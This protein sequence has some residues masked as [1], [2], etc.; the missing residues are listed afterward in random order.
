M[1]WLGGI[2]GVLLWVSSAVAGPL[3]PGTGTCPSGQA[4]TAL[5]PGGPPRCASVGGSGS[6]PTPPNAPQILFSN[7]GAAV[8]SAAVPG[9]DL[10]INAVGQLN[11]QYGTQTCST[12][13]C[14]ISSAN[15]ICNSASGPITLLLPPAMAGKVEDINL[16]TTAT[17]VC[18]L[19]AQGG[20]LINGSATFAIPN[21]QNEVQLIGNAAGSWGIA[22]V[23]YPPAQTFAAHN[24]VTGSTAGKLSA[25]QPACSDLTGAAAHCGTNASELTSGTLPTAQL[26]NPLPP[27]NIPAPTAST[28]GG[29]NSIASQSHKFVNSIGT[30]GLP[31]LAQPASTDLSDIP[32]PVSSGCTGHS[33]AGAATANA[34][35]AAA[36]GNNADIT[37]LSAFIGPMTLAQGGT[38]CPTGPVNFNNLPAL[39]VAGETCVIKDPSGCTAQLGTAIVN[40]GGSCGNQTWPVTFNGL[41]NCGNGTQNCWMPGGNAQS[42]GTQ[43]PIN[44]LPSQTA[45][46]NANAQK[47][48]NVACPSL[49]NDVLAQACAASVTTATAT[50]SMTTPFIQTSASNPAASGLVRAA[51]NTTISAARNSSNNGDVPVSSVD[52]ANN[53][54]LGG[55]GA[56]GL[57]LDVPAA[58]A[59][60]SF[61][62]GDFIDIPVPNV[63][64]MGGADNCANTYHNYT[65]TAAN[66]VVTFGCPLDG[67]MR[68]LKYRIHQP[69]TGSTFSYTFSAGNNPIFTPLGGGL[70]TPCAS[71]NCYDDYDVTFDGAFGTVSVAYAGTWA[72][73][74]ATPACGGTTCYYVDSVGGNDANAGTFAAP[75]KNVGPTSTVQAKINAGSLAGVQILFKAG[76]TWTAG[77][78]GWS[79]GTGATTVP[80]INL[81][82][83]TNGSANAPFVIGS[84]GTGAAPLFNG[85]NGIVMACVWASATGTGASPIFSYVT[86]N[87]LECKNTAQAGIYFHTVVGGTAGMPG[88]IASSNNIHNTGPGCST[89]TGTCTTAVDSSTVCGTYCNQ[90]EFLDENEKSDGTIFTNNVVHDCGG[91][92][93]IQIHG[94]T[95]GPVAKNNQCYGWDH[96]CIDLKHVVN[97]LV[98]GNT[99]HQNNSNGGSC[100]YYENSGALQR[101]SITW[102]SNVVYSAPNGFQCEGGTS[103]GT[104]CK[105]YNNT[106]FVGDST[107][108]I[109]SCQPSGACPGGGSLAPLWDVENNIFD[110]SAPLFVCNAFQ[111]NSC[112]DIVTWNYNDDGGHTA[113]APSMSGL[114]GMSGQAANDL[115]NQDPLY[116]SIGVNNFQL[117]AGSP[118]IAAGRSGLTPGNNDMGAF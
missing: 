16:P 50:T 49:A 92:N 86:V 8:W 90:L 111:T 91:H 10:V 109:L 19:Q 11:L 43:V 35:G 51:N 82:S 47:L 114:T 65:V 46:Y 103:F 22:N 12:S 6:L 20:D 21:A 42:S 62:S 112:G 17:N 94:D 34:I 93:C 77:G 79:G 32:C 116:V 7:S 83:G 38:N 74:S 88:I 26:P 61:A 58:T 97:G 107:S 28:L 63:N 37:Q 44:Q 84:Y 24:F 71:N 76:D 101:G 15:V 45:A 113:G 13:P 59:G 105:A 78:A 29:V 85:S 40:G 66:A 104:D 18:T 96:N 3:P 60:V 73:L 53:V 110:T 108:C 115:L 36:L 55:A 52:T 80:M 57:S 39:P 33:S 31:T 5:V 14:T 72:A 95:G 75:F 2:A 70:P 87:G 41:S 54:H 30:N 56:N 64:W 25:A 99:C 81:P 67:K 23:T 102:Q 48:Q 1:K 106:C 68:R 117:S 27:A 9:G 98:T 118:C 100:Y 89:T 69:A 4:V